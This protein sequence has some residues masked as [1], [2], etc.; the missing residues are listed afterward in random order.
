MKRALVDVNVVLDVLLARAPH[1]ATSTA[2]LAAV[3]SNRVEGLLS[4]HAVTTLAYLAARALG[5]GG[6]RRAIDD[7]CAIFAI[8]TVDEAVIRRALALDLADFED[9]VTAAAAEAAGCE[10]IVTRDVAGFKG[11]P[12]PA[13]EP[14][15]WLVLLAD[16]PA[17]D[18]D[19]DLREPESAYGG[20]RRR[21]TSTQAAARGGKRGRRAAR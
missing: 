5:K 12:V 1:A 6:A 14:V 19:P 21:R 4:A 20:K 3:E 11:S 9:G 7:L 10:A 13:L 17:G 18:S 16:R 2:C 15:L 8:A